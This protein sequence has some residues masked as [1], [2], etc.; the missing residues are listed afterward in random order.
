MYAN[1]TYLFSARDNYFSLCVLY[2]SNFRHSVY[3]DVYTLSHSDEIYLLQSKTNYVDFICLF[4]DSCSYIQSPIVSIQYI[5]FLNK[6][7]ATFHSELVDGKM[8]RQSQNQ[9][10]QYKN[11]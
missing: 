1:T 5:A 11:M 8:L 2:T 4:S 9:R 10:L 3:R 6:A 7:A